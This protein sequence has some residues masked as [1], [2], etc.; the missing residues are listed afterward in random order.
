MTTI[1][2]D[3]WLKA[4]EEAGVSTVDDQQAITIAEFA[5]LFQL[6]VSTASRQLRTL[7]AQG[8][9]VETRKTS[10]ARDGRR[11]SHVAFRMVD[12]KAKKRR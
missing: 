2:R 10:A 1:C 11:V 5:A 8:R 12:Q 3:E 6:T 7:V 9:A 4:L